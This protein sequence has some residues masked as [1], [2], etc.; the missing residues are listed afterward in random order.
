M[1]IINIINNDKVII[2]A[3]LIATK[4]FHDKSD[5]V[6]NKRVINISAVTTT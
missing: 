4:D 5:K 3:S 1:L 6:S 2:E